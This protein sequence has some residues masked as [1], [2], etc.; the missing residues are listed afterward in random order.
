MKIATAGE[1]WGLNDELWLLKQN[2][3]KFVE[4][5][6]TP[7]FR[8]C[9]D[10]ESAEKFYREAMRKM[11]EQGFL[12]VGVPER[13]GGMGLGILGTLIV[14]EE[15]T[16]GNGALGI[17]AMEN[18][19][20]GCMI[21]AYSPQ[22]WA[23]WGEKLMSGEA[24]YAGATTAPEGNSNMPAWPMDFAR[25]DGDEWVLNG[26][27]AFSSGGTF[28][29]IIEVMC[30]AGGEMCNFV[31]PVGTPGMIIHSNPE[32]GNS[33]T[34]ASITFK[35]CRI[36]KNYGGPVEYTMETNDEELVGFGRKEFALGC[37]ALALGAMG[38]AYDETVEYLSNKVSLGKKIVEYGAIQAKFVDMKMKMEAARSLLYTAAHM[39]ACMHKDAGAWC[40]MAKIFCCETANEITC[41]CIPMFGCL[42]VNPDTG[43]ARHHLDAIGFSIGVGTTDDLIPGTAESLGFPPSD[44]LCRV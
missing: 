23:E 11:G 17:H 35:D 31:V 22:A 18:Q 13:L 34:Y 15:V 27:K 1:G 8:E 25:L 43:I 37:A 20:L 36:P 6:I 9:Y 2:V 33:P 14:T 10:E 19:I 16:R 12:S 3:R 4:A 38:A 44:D 29:D 42:G 5:E 41:K 7:R 26:E 21:S 24:I 30:F 28:A 39:S 32:L 40:N